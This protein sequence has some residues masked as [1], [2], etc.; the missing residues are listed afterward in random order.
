MM[1]SLTLEKLDANLLEVVGYLGGSRRLL[2]PGF[3][4][5]IVVMTISIRLLHLEPL[6][7]TSLCFD[8]SIPSSMEVHLSCFHDNKSW[9]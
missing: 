6:K 9:K 8:L 2:N 3:K 7:A 1:L 5:L 4:L